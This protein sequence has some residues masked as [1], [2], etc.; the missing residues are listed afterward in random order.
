MGSLEGAEY[1]SP[2]MYHR[3][4]KDS[5]RNERNTSKLIFENLKLVEM[6]KNHFNII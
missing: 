1:F 5:Y 6:S 3:V 2:K 4:F